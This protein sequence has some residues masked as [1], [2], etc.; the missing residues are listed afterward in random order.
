MEVPLVNVSGNL[1][2][3]GPLRH[4]YNAEEIFDF[5]YDVTPRNGVE[6]ETSIMPLVQFSI[7]PQN[8]DNYYDGTPRYEFDYEIRGLTKDSRLLFSTL[9][10]KMTPKKGRWFDNR[11][12]NFGMKNS[13]FAGKDTAHNYHNRRNPLSSNITNI[14]TSTYTPIF[15]SKHTT[16]EFKYMDD[17]MI[18]FNETS[19]RNADEANDTLRNIL[20]HISNTD[21]NSSVY[22]VPNISAYNIKNN[23]VLNNNNYNKEILNLNSFTKKDIRPILLSAKPLQNYKKSQNRL[24]LLLKE[25][26][27]NTLNVNNIQSEDFPTTDSFNN[28]EDINNKT[29]EIF[30]N[31]TDFNKGLQ[32]VITTNNNTNTKVSENIVGNMKSATTLTLNNDSAIT[33]E[34]LIETGTMVDRES[35]DNIV[36]AAPVMAVVLNKTEPFI[37]SNKNNTTNVEVISDKKTIQRKKRYIQSLLIENSRPRNLTTK[38]PMR[39]DPEPMFKL[40]D[41]QDL[42]RLVEL[43][44]DEIEGRVA[45]R[46]V[47]NYVGA[48]LFNICDFSEAKQR[49]TF[50]F[51]ASRI[52]I[53]VSNFTL[54]RIMLVTTAAQSLLNSESRCPSGYL[55]CQVVGTRVCIDS[56]NACDG[57]PNCGSYDIYDEDKLLCGAS[58]DLQHN[59]YLAAFTFL[60]VLLTMIYTVHYWLKRCVPGVSEAFFVYTD[61]SEN[62]LFLDTVMRSPMDVDDS[63]CK[64]MFSG[65]FFDDDILYE[66]KEANVDGNVLT[67]MFRKCFEFCFCKRK[68]EDRY[69]KDNIK[70]FDSKPSGSTNM[71]PFTELELRKYAHINSKDEAIQTCESY[72]QMNSKEVENK[73]QDVDGIKGSVTVIETNA[74]KVDYAKELSI[75]KFA[76]ETR[77]AS[78]ESDSISD[79]QKYFKTDRR[80]A[81]IIENEK[82]IKSTIYDHR[83]N[84]MAPD[85]IPITCEVHLEKHNKR[86][87]LR[88]LRFEDVPTMIPD[89]ENDEDTVSTSTARRNVVL[90]VGHKKQDLEAISETEEAGSSSKDFMRFWGGKGKKNKKKEKHFSMH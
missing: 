15:N 49:Q 50:L 3:G 81:I 10:K 60:A 19:T 1:Q 16:T 82:E 84:K 46:Y 52:V 66:D 65:H 79:D 76:K 67:K 72:D 35:W 53:A 44:D 30:E 42:A 28:V 8:S 25:L 2:L 62:T 69:S 83:S 57:V 7:R 39:T 11:K 73:L 54:D 88:R 71:F 40:S 80:H 89:T 90:G 34:R 37:H 48:V 70:E 9:N 55:E 68:R 77:S 22:L 13:P 12:Y 61:T 38:R 64:L 87:D 78:S 26:S 56:T 47:R 33:T 20:H 29:I 32:N 21:H 59:V 74:H 41:V 4:T 75:I 85:S 5:I 58:K 24:N 43:Q 36:Q 51:N 23:Y 86:E 14:I 45:L 6:Y 27:N 63:S 31:K 18:Y 17:I